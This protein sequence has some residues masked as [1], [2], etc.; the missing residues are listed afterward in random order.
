MR[1][2]S[3][4][5]IILLTLSSYLLASCS[6]TSIEGNWKEPE[7]DSRYV[8]P[9]II[10]ISDSQQNRQIFEK[11][12]VEKLKQG[13]VH[14]I[15]SYTMISSKQKINRETVV[16]AI[17][18][19]D[20]D[21]VLVRGAWDDDDLPEGMPKDIFYE[22]RKVWVS[23]QQLKISRL[24]EEK[25]GKGNPKRKKNEK[26]IKSIKKKS[27]QKKKVKLNEDVTSR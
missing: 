18:G 12:F 24:S 19:T 22:L 1:L 9:L 4:S 2:T 16:D 8:Q 11:Q 5:K 25:A 10:G 17:Q 23:G 6:H 15:P 20:I 27:K 7:L 21:A 3:F 14:A 26:S 13:N